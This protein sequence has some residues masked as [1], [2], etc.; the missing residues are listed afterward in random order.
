MIFL[1]RHTRRRLLVRLVLVVKYG[2]S[3][4]SIL[5]EANCLACKY[6]QLESC[7]SDGVIART[8]YMA[9]SIP[10][11][12]LGQIG[13]PTSAN[14]AEDSHTTYLPRLVCSFRLK[15]QE[16]LRLMLPPPWEYCI[17]HCWKQLRDQSS[18]RPLR[19]RKRGSGGLLKRK[20]L[21]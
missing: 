11:A 4:K 21:G 1:K 10:H 2:R 5:S 7:C 6:D 15:Y 8:G 9:T 16:Q 20:S 3:F 19:S 14:R 18:G 17:R 12:S 13:M